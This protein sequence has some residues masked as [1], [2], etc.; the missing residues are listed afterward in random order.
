MLNMTLGRYSLDKTIVQP[1]DA[2]RREKSDVE[3]IIKAVL[4]SISSYRVGKEVA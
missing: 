2:G 3:F 1:G 4:F